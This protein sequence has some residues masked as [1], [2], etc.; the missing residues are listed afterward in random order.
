MRYK[1][2]AC[3][4]LLLISTPVFSQEFSPIV[5][6]TGK[7]NP[8][9]VKSGE[10]FRVTYRA[11]FFDT[12]LIFEERM[13][14][15]NLVMEKIEVIDL[16]IEPKKREYNDSLGYLN[17]WDFTYTFRIIQ[18]EKEAYKIPPFNFIWAEKRA[19]VSDE[20]TREKEKPREFLT[21]EVGVNYVS[22]I[23]K[24]PA[25]DIRDEII[26]SSPV[27]S[28]AVLRRWAYGV[29]GMALLFLGLIIFRF[30]RNL[31]ARKSRGSDGESATEVLDIDSVADVG[32]IL[33]PKQAR[34]KFLAELEKMGDGGQITK[35]RLLVRMLLLSELFG[36]IKNS[37]SDNEI[38]F[39]LNNLD[40]KQKKQVGSKYPTM[41]YLVGKLKDYQDCTDFNKS[42]PAFIVG[43][44]K[45]RE[46]VSALTFRNKFLFFA[47]RLVGRRG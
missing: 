3:A 15:S 34:K 10:P 23:V 7:P 17:V 22:S 12:V 30:P 21:E 18:P 47:K 35:V 37:M 20:E 39:K 9:V 32:Q 31:K 25:L 28:G 45:L 2:L 6:E 24:P 42:S 16:K 40:A 26:F 46:A 14:P 5:I 43:T 33:P 13:Q 27:A 11:K 44:A 29:I 41:L 36:I 19:G 4:F 8:S 1:F 38:Y